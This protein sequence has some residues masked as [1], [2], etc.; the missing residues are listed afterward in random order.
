[1]L[2]I[3]SSIMPRF[4]HLVIET[5]QLFVDGF[6]ENTLNLTQLLQTLPPPAPTDP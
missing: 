5:T 2:S 4:L 1:M 3:L 6:F